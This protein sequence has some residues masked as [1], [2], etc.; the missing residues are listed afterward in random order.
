M[1]EAYK[2]QLVQKAKA[3]AAKK[4]IPVKRGV[5]AAVTSPAF[6]TLAEYK[7]ILAM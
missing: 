7:M 6:E 3:I 1:N 4:N 2:K 5:Y